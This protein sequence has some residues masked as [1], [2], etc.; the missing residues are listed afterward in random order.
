MTRSHLDFDVHLVDL[1]SWSPGSLLVRSWAPLLP[2]LLSLSLLLA[3][4]PLS[5]FSWPSSVWVILDVSGYLPPHIYNKPSLQPHL[6]PSCTHYLLQKR[7]FKSGTVNLTKSSWFW[8]SQTLR[9]NLVL[10]SCLI[11]LLTNWLLNSCVYNHRLVLPSILTRGTFPHKEQELCRDFKLSSVSQIS[12]HSALNELCQHH[13]GPGPPGRD[14]S[15]GEKCWLLHGIAIALMNSHETVTASTGST[16]R[17]E[18][19]AKI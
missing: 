10:L 6:R 9:K 5:I 8:R 16:H 11:G 15:S 17:T 14:G 18:R 4:S 12:E 1:V 3:L 2:S 13:K 7:E 19:A